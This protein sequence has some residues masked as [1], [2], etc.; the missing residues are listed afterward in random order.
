MKR[1]H[2]RKP[3]RAKVLRRAISSKGPGGATPSG[4]HPLQPALR[5]SVLRKCHSQLFHCPPLPFGTLKGHELKGHSLNRTQRIL[6]EECPL[7]PLRNVPNVIKLS[8]KSLGQWA[9]S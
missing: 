9:L 8:H 3:H 6:F 4:V 2:R 7:C 5:P 1:S